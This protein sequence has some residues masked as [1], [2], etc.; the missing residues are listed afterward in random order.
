MPFYSIPSWLALRNFCLYRLRDDGNSFYRA[1]SLGYYR[2]DEF[3]LALR[4]MLMEHIQEDPA[5]YCAP[6][7]KHL[8]D[9]RDPRTLQGLAAS[10][11]HEYAWRND[12]FTESVVPSGIADMLNI[13]LEIYQARH[14]EPWS[15]SRRVYGREH[16]GPVIRLMRINRGH[17]GLLEKQQ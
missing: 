8:R 3:H 15:Q 2:D 9:L 13:R 14:T 16:D 17:Y 7:N 11:K 6:P 4:R 1:V 10:H 12:P 5:S